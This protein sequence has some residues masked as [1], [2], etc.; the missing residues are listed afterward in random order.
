MLADFRGG[1]QALNQGYALR[2]LFAGV[3]RA[4]KEDKTLKN[5]SRQNWISF[6]DGGQE[7][8]LGDAQG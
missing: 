4:P 8:L 3:R 2:S 1:G 5:V 6:Q 7:T